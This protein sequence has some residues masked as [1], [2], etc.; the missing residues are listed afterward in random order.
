MPT[1]TGYPTCPLLQLSLLLF[2]SAGKRENIKN[3]PCPTFADIR[4]TIRALT[5]LNLADNQLKYEGAELVI[6]MLPQV[7]GAVSPLRCVDGTPYES[8]KSF[9]MSTH[10]CKHCGQHK[11]VHS[12]HIVVGVLALRAMD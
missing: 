10:I 2:L 3:I 1:T 8:E 6:K 9:M 4:L 11:S 7:A 5:S 12:E